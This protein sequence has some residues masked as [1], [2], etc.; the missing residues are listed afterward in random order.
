MDA[1]TPS[2]GEGGHL[3][4][5][6]Q[7]GTHSHSHAA[8][9]YFASSTPFDAYDH[10][11]PAD[12]TSPQTSSVEQPRLQAMERGRPY[13]TVERRSYRD[14][15]SAGDMVISREE[16]A[17]SISRASS[18]VGGREAVGAGAIGDKRRTP[19]STTTTSLPL[20]SLTQAGYPGEILVQ[21]T[22]QSTAPLLSSSASA[23]PPRTESPSTLDSTTSRGIESLS[24]RLGALETIVHSD[25]KSLREEVAVLRDLVLRSSSFGAGPPRIASPSPNQEYRFD[26]R[27]QMESSSYLLPIDPSRNTSQRPYLDVPLPST[28]IEPP[29]PAHSAPGALYPDRS[30][31]EST[32]RMSQFEKDQQLSI[33]SS[34]MSALSSSVAR[35][36]GTT[37]SPIP[38]ASP[39]FLS[40]RQIISPMMSSPVA[41]LIGGGSPSLAPLVE[42][43]KRDVTAGLGVTGAGIKDGTSDWSSGTTRPRSAGGRTA[44]SSPGLF[45]VEDKRRS[46][47]PFGAIGQSGLRSDAGFDASS[48]AGNWDGTAPSSPLVGLVGSSIL[49][50]PPGSLGGKWEALGVGTELFRTIAKYG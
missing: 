50:N 26:G 48:T 11:F 49:A 4:P 24:R 7:P 13:P 42:G 34:Q 18:V 35:L 33:L 1:T 15:S 21:D 27:D 43:W 23:S 9:A 17:A 20:D 36:M 5:T 16:V 2:L 41:G 28:I 10:G 25:L 29:S 6:P 32:P 44:R 8:A 22:P 47:M 37:S 40:Q 30:S 31:E 12:S 45:G 38:V 14:V 46:Q 3:S 39:R 19:T